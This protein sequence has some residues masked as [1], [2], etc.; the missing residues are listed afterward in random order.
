VGG[1]LKSVAYANNPHGLE[2]LKQN[3]REVIYTIQQCELQQVFQNLFKKIHACLT[4][5]GKHFEYFL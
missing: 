1:T 3:I 2:A 5:G 4:A